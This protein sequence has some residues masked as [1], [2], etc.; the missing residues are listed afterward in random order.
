MLCAV[1]GGSGLTS[2][3][4]LEVVRRETVSTP[5]GEPSAAMIHG[6]LAGVDVVF[7]PRHGAEHTIPA[8][9][10]NY[11]ANVWALK[12]AQVTHVLA[13]N[14]VGGIRAGLEPG[15]LLIPDQIVDYTGSRAHTF[16]EHDLSQVVHVDFTHPYSGGLRDLI[17]RAAKAGGVDVW[18]G[19][20]Y[21]ATQGPRFE[22]AAEIDRME[23]DGCDVVGMTGM[24]EAALA[25]ELDIDYAAVTVVVNHAA[26][27][28][29][30]EI[31]M[32][33]IEESLEIGIGKVCTVLEQVLPLAAGLRGS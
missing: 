1:I 19:G 31:S 26:G 8:H 6:V 32:E 4:G 12:Q 16:Y 29:P 30:S 11:R 20:T 3:S 15:E 9:Q 5:F 33:H 17:S 14:A 22:S 24:P 10:I 21:G 27:R 7:L 25:R 2:L 18:E 23:K 28:G 13:V